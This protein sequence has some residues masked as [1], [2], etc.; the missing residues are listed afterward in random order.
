MDDSIDLISE[1]KVGIGTWSW[2][3]RLM[4]GYGREYDELELREA[5]KLC[6]A[7]GQRFFDTAEIYGQGKSETLLGKFIKESGEKVFVATKF[8]P[9]PW[10][11]NR[12]SLLKALRG[13][14]R[15]LQLEKVDLYQIHMPM[16]PIPIETWMGA[17]AEAFHAGQIGAVGVSNYDYGQT[18]RA[19][20]ALIRNGLRLATNQVE[21]SL[22][23]RK[24]EKNGLI[25]QCKDLGIKIIAYSPLGMGLLSGKYSA[26]NPPSGLRGSRFSK[27][28]LNRIQPLIHLLRKIG[29]DHDGKS[30]A[31]VAMNW[32][33][34]KG[35]L[36]IP[37]VKN[38]IQA[39]QVNGAIG[40]Q[41]SEE[42]RVKLEETSDRISQED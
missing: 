39:E 34:D 17:L 35:C 14:L 10:R 3:D 42:E 23:N 1:L 28:Y 18:M 41:L 19:Y 20:D 12:R 27:R 40:W 11:L 2:G 5:F 31:Q 38:S 33:M 24:I 16:P 7:N 36:I 22:L 37:G 29:A 9:Y 26:E 21:Y 8:M 15:R 30:A 32:A 25:Q 4:W 13:S 6:L